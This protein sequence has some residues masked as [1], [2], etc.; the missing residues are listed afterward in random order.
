MIDCLM[1]FSCVSNSAYWIIVITSE[2]FYEKWMLLSIIRAP[3]CSC[4]ATRQLPIDKDTLE[5]PRC[6]NISV[7][8]AFNIANTKFFTHC[9]ISYYHNLAIFTARPFSHWGDATA[10]RSR[11]KSTA[12]N[13]WRVVITSWSRWWEKRHYE[14]K[15]RPVGDCKVIFFIKSQSRRLSGRTA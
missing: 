9:L 15:V 3:I 8:F 14:L 10:T 12:L 1:K 2:T 6:N 13:S 4:N 5:Q 7:C 11:K